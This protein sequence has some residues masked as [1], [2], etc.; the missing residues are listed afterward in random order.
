MVGHLVVSLV[1]LAS[2]AAFAG[3]PDVS[4]P[5]VARPAREEAAA[6]KDGAGGGRREKA[7]KGSSQRGGSGGSSAKPPSTTRDGGAP[8]DGRGGDAKPE[9]REPSSARGEADRGPERPA[10]NRPSGPAGARPA[11]HGP[12]QAPSRTISAG[13]PRSPTGPGPAASP[14]RSAPRPMPAN[15]RPPPAAAHGAP[16]PGHRGPPPSGSHAANTAAAHHQAAAAHHGARPGGH[17]AAAAHHQAWARAYRGAHP[18]RFWAYRG[19]VVW[20]P[21]YPRYWYHGV[22]VYGPP[23]YARQSAEVVEKGPKRVIDRDD[24]WAVGA[25]GGTYASGYTNGAA[26]SDFGMG[27]AVRYRPAD[28]LGLELQWSY[29]D[30]SWDASTARIDQPLSAS[31]QLFAFPWTR[32]NPYVLAGVTY[33]NRNVQDDI[34]QAFVDNDHPVWG[35]HLGVGLELGIGK[36]W[37][38]NGDLRGIGY[39]ND[40]GED[41]MRQGATQANLGVNRYF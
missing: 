34:G 28:A 18:A 9:S 31:V 3:G 40:G 39:L 1:L 16:P 7:G 27:L 32:F 29:H 35:P 12:A 26:Y 6:K 22:F 15:L 19:P 33:T 5:D 17:A 38:V 24:T 4:A 41:L 23:P 2:N 10:E 25:R 14:G 13:A 21:G 36:N 37:S 30:Q 11:D 8:A 20:Y